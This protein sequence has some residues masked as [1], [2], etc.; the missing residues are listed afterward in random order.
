[1]YPDA[2]SLVLGGRWWHAAWLR[3]WKGRLA[4]EGVPDEQRMAMQMAA[5]P[6]FVPRQHLLQ[7][8]I[9]EAVQGMVL[10]AQSRLLCVLLPKVW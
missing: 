2:Q 6:K 7:V 5:S 4:E 10:S 9:C 3:V 8:R 1:M